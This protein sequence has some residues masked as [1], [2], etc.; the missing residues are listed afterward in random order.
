[1]KFL[2]RHIT[3]TFFF[4]KMMTGFVVQGLNWES[5]NTTNYL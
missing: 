1:M 2:A 3:K 5:E 4:Q